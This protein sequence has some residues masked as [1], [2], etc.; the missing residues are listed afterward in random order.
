MN[1]QPS[2]RQGLLRKSGGMIHY[3]EP[4]SGH[5]QGANINACLLTVYS[6]SDLEYFVFPSARKMNEKEQ[7]SH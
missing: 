1:V 6:I 2:G 5:P 3:M 4:C 7:T